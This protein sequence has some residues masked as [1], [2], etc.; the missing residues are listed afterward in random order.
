MHGGGGRAA[1][2]KEAEQLK[3]VAASTERSDTRDGETG[4][5]SILIV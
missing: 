3:T 1:A 2:T 5:V 4:S